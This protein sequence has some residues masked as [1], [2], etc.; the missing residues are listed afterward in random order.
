MF[1]AVWMVGVSVLLLC[2]GRGKTP[3]EQ[4]LAYCHAQVKRTLAELT[5]ESGQTDYTMMPRNI[6]KGE[7]RWECRPVAPEE[8]CSGFWPGV[9]WYDYENT[10]DERIRVEAERFTRKLLP[11]LD[12]PA[13]DHDLGFLMLAS[14]GQAYRLTGN[15]EYKQVLV[16]AADS[17]STLF[18]SRVGAMLSWPRHV[19]DYGAHN[20]IIDNMMNLE[21]LYWAAANGGNPCLADIATSHA[22][23][24]MK[25]HFRNDFT[26]YH[27]AL[28]DTLSGDFIRALNH[29]GYADESRWARGQAWAIYGYTMVYR[30]TH[31]WRFLD[32]ARRVADA[33]LERLPDDLVPY[34][35]FD[36]PD[37]PN[38]P[39]DASAA[40]IVAS[41]FLEMS[42]Y[43]H[44]GDGERYVGLAR[45]MLQSLGSEAYRCGQ[46]SPAFLHHSTGHKPAGTEIDASII[47][48]DYYYIEALTRLRK[49]EEIM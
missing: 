36:D 12:R 2:C 25:Y 16:R 49:I 14:F 6:A 26:C 30:E 4:A 46:A 1:A 33:Y 27:V 28:Y 43:L 8:W 15:S 35:D 17:L 38:A 32:F 24:T 20:V 9:L 31:D 41:A 18:R 23:K 21:L 19:S 34:W 5:D 47:Y 42:T 45:Q 22:D 44:N 3:T 37:I 29:Q 13:Y 40:C 11:I 39:R 7:S 10:G 48:A